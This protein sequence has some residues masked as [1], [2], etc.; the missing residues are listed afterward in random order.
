MTQ[1]TPAE[2]KTWWQ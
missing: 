1:I 2:S